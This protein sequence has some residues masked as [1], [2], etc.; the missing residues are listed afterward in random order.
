MLRLVTRRAARIKETATTPGAGG[1]MPGGAVR[2][3]GEAPINGVSVP[4]IYHR[5]LVAAVDLATA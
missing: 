5:G 2:M 1:A 4:P 3:V